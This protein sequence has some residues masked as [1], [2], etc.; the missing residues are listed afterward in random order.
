MKVTNNIKETIKREIVQCLSGER[1]IKKII[2][3]GSFLKFNKPADI[4]IAIFQESKESY[5][6]LAMKYRKL[7]RTVSKK[8]PLDIIP[9]RPDASD[10]SF[11]T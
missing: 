3:F 2:I 4:D 10:S 8:I 9:I 1:E 11:L 5:L 7:T 6:S